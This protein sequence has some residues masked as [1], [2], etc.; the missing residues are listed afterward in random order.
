MSSGTSPTPVVASGSSRGTAPA[1]VPLRGARRVLRWVLLLIALVVAAYAEAEV[2]RIGRTQRELKAQQQ[3]NAVAYTEP[4]KAAVA[5]K[6]EAS[7]GQF[8]ATLAIFAV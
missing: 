5:Q 8:Q 3:F 2:E 6:L 4:I 1:A 7:K